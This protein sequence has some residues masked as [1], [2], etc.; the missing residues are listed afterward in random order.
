MGSGVSEEYRIAQTSMRSSIW[1]SRR[2]SK[3]K[4]SSH[5]GLS[6]DGQSRVRRTTLVYRPDSVNLQYGSDVPRNSL[7]RL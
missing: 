1:R 6:V 5:F 2:I 3:Q 4:S 7:L